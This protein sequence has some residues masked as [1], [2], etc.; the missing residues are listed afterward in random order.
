MLEG[1]A[2]V[3]V[4]EGTAG[5]AVEGMGTDWPLTGGGTMTVLAT[6]RTSPT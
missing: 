2:G 5:V 4:L 1:T 6:Q 3:V